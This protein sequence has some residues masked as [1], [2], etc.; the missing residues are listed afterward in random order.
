MLKS[1]VL[2]VFNYLNISTIA[3][4]LGCF[5]LV[6]TKGFIKAE[7]RSFSLPDYDVPFVFRGY[8][9]EQERSLDWLIKRRIIGLGVEWM[10]WEKRRVP[11]VSIT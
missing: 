10:Q 5:Y 6:L 1:T 11:Y 3:L 7:I 4:M 8:E 9:S 2:Y